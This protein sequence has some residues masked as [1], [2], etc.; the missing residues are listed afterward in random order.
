MPPEPDFTLDAFQKPLFF[1]GAGL[2]AESGI[3]TYRGLGSSGRRYNW[4]EVACQR[5]FEEDPE[6]VW[7]FH[8]DR[9]AKVARAEPN[10]GH[11]IIARVLEQRP[12]GI[13]VTQNI[14]GLLQAA[15]CP[16]ERVVELHGSLW[17]VRSEQTGRVERNVQLPI[18]SRRAPDGGYWR[19]DVVWFEDPLDPHVLE[20]AR[21]A[22][23]ECDIL[24][25]VGTSAVVYPAAE[26]P[27][28]ALARGIPAVEVNPEETPLSRLYTHALRM[29]AS[30]A[31]GR[32]AGGLA[33]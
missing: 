11:R 5:A 1:T 4:R 16:H 23:V 22:M 28:L 26:L 19:P 3:A 10:P 33:V 9:R 15:G 29:P 25:S 8:D 21:D 2:S 32:L 24:V 17:R 6:R 13:A 20:R 7:D 31:L 27:R 30:T 14:D 18:A 12:G